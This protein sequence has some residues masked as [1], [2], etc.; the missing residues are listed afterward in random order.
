VLYGKT[1]GVLQ[2]TKDNSVIL[3]PFMIAYLHETDN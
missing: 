2:T 1:Y 3:R